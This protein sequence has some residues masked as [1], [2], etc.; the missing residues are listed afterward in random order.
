MGLVMSYFPRANHSSRYIPMVTLAVIFLLILGFLIQTEV[1]AVDHATVLKLRFSINSEIARNGHLLRL[2]TANFFHVNSGHLL[3]NI[4]GLLFFSSFLEIFL[5][6]TRITIIILLS[7]LG[8]TV[9][10]LLFHMVDWMVGASTIVFGV[11]GGLGVLL[12]RYRKEFHRYF[13]TAA[14][15]WCVSLIPMVALGYLSLERVDQG[16]HLGGFLVG[17]LSTWVMVKGYPL[18]EINQPPGVKIRILLL[19][20]LALFG[21]SLVRE[22]FPL[23]TR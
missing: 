12:L 21:L 14:I 19:V 1:G 11:F 10:S 18:A 17:A 4:V 16:A 8:G 15:S 22:V 5:G 6:K 23:L 9:G 20:L 7:A 3:T 13:A 2:F